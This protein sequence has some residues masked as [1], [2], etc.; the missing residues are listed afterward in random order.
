M[1][2]RLYLS[3]TNNFGI[4][5]FSKPDFLLRLENLRCFRRVHSHLVFHLLS[6]MLVVQ[7]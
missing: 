6:V 5:I 7:I 3:V 2:V 1:T 4:V